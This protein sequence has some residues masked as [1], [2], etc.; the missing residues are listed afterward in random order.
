MISPPP[1]VHTS[2][3]VTLSA[4]SVTLPVLVIVLEELKL[5]VVQS[6]FFALMFNVLF[7][8]LTLSVSVILL[9]VLS[10]K[11]NLVELKRVCNC[12]SVGIQP[13]PQF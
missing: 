1:I 8:M 13:D 7:A 6:V 11:D 10:P 4:T 12:D 3:K 2:P 9:T 5:V